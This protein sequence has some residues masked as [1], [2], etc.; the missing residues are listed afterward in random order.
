M[1]TLPRVPAQV[2][3][4]GCDRSEAVEAEV[5]G[6]LAKLEEA[7]GRLT[8]ARVVVH[9]PHKHH[10]KGNI[11]H[12][13]ID[14]QVPGAGHVVKHETGVDHAHED[15]YVAVRDAFK[16]VQRNLKKMVERRRDAERNAMQPEFG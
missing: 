7:Y 12:V 1:K 3:F 8:G 16:A 6:K 5:L 15:V 9:T 2:L 10:H 11:F 14:V 13:D 4:R